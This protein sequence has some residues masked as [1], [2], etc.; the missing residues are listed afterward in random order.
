MLLNNL[1][2]Y[3]H[4]LVKILPSDFIL[5]NKKIRS[6][7]VVEPELDATMS[8]HVAVAGDVFDISQAVFDGLLVRAVYYGVEKKF[9]FDDAEDTVDSS[10]TGNSLAF[11]NL[12]ELSMIL[13]ELL[14]FDETFIQSS[15]NQCFYK[16]C[17]VIDL[18]KPI[19][20]LEE[21][22]NLLF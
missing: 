18:Q 7:L 11:V 16:L 13:V 22:Q 6:L 5:K 21:S 2:L 20:D 4:E 3:F 14:E 19:V 12:F 10:F 8:E 15:I 17:L 1:K 9:V